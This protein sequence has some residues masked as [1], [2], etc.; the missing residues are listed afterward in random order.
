[1][2]YIPA[3][4]FSMGSNDGFDDEKPPHDVDLAGYW[5][6]QTEITNQMFASFLNEEGNQSEGGETW[7]DP[8]DSDVQIHIPWGNTWRADSGVEDHPVIDVT[9]FGA[10]AYCKWRGGRLPTEEEW[11]KAASWDDDKKEKRVYP[12][13][14]TFIGNL[15]NFCDANCQFDHGDKSVNDGYE[16]TSPVGHYSG[17][18]SFYG[19]LDMSGNVSEW[20]SDWYKAYPGNTDSTSSY[21]E[22]YRVLRG[23]SWYSDPRY[24]GSSHRESFYPDVALNT[25][26]FRCARDTSP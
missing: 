17:G 9:W 22:T 25:G 5:I 4:E 10:R 15:L 20:V 7:M 12:W 11:E 1:M 21:G 3:G 16:F 14:D 26:G 8:Y 6:D 13:G 18:A 2:L 23:G 24:L 19:L